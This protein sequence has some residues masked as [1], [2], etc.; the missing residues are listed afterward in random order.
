MQHACAVSQIAD[1][2]TR[3]RGKTSN[4]RSTRT[5]EKKEDGASWLVGG[6]QNGT[7]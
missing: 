2:T 1:K 6:G 7:P 5:V 4:E 3:Q